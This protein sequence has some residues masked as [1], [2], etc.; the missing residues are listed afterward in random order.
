MVYDDGTWK[1]DRLHTDIMIFEMLFMQDR[2]HALG[3]LSDEDYAK[4][5]NEQRKLIIQEF[6]RV[7]N[8][9]PNDNLGK[10]SK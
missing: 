6:I 10:E 3:R 7:S 4:F 1:L 9:S 5:L 2:L 8:S